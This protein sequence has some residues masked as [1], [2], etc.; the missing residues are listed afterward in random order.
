MTELSWLED[1]GEKIYKGYDMSALKMDE[2][3]L[4]VNFENPGEQYRIFRKHVDCVKVC[5]FYIFYRK[6]ISATNGA[7]QRPQ[8]S[9]LQTPKSTLR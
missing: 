9:Y 5:L 2:A 8:N 6:N 4:N 1:Y 3:Y 7:L